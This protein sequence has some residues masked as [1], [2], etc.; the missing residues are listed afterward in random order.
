MF[1]STRKLSTLTDVYDLVTNL[2]SLLLLLLEET[3]HMCDENI[4]VVNINFQDA[5]W[6]RN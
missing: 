6:Q 3:R 2:G 1:P 4:C 5:G